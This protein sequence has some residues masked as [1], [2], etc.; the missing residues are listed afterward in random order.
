MPS[1][2][3]LIVLRT[4]PDIALN[5]LPLSR[6]GA[7]SLARGFVMSEEVKKS[8]EMEVKGR[9]EFL[10]TA[11]QVAVTA[12][13][14]AMLLTATTKQSKAAFF[15]DQPNIGDDSTSD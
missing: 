6:K 15:Y 5:S 9:R 10:K 7:R 14:A 8:E 3:N 2:C 13:A 12:P 11:V 4:G 1:L